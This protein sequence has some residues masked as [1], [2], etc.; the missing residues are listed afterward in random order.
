MKS[1]IRLN[2]TS[3]IKKI[4]EHSFTIESYHCFKQVPLIYEYDG[5]GR[6]ISYEEQGYINTKINYEYN[7]S[8]EIQKKICNKEGFIFKEIF[9][10]DENG[11]LIKHES[12]DVIV[13]YKYNDRK[14]LIE[15]KKIN[16]DDLYEI[17]RIT[18]QYD[19]QGNQIKK[20][21]FSDK[22]WVNKRD[23]NGNIIEENEY[24]GC[25]LLCTITNNYNEWGKLCG[26][27]SW[28]D[29]NIF[30]ENYWIEY[31]YDTYQ[32][33]I[34]ENKYSS[35]PPATDLI[36]KIVHFYDYDQ[37]G[38]W[39]IKKTIIDEILAEIVVREIDY[40]DVKDDSDWDVFG[41]IF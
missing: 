6:L 18:Y 7:E 3:K 38:N 14:N 12:K 30:R 40:Y 20:K 21:D 22:S 39:L 9:N 29:D 41:G 31:K 33:L 24:D 13:T 5:M 11:N 28:N 36:K 26:K 2:V 1:L 15:E 17:S 19:N 34:E 35:G 27:K 32:N 10:Y 8:D 23:N 16:S 4:K 25:L 37:A